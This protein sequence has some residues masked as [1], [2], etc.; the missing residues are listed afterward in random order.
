MSNPREGYQEEDT[1]ELKKEEEDVVGELRPQ[2]EDDYFEGDDD[3]DGFLTA[4][5]V[6]S[7]LKMAGSS[8][9]IPKSIRKAVGG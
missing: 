4:D 2:G 8:G 1:E 5:H 9:T 6:N 7:N 3:E